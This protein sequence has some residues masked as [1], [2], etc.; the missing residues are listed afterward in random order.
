MLRLAVCLDYVAIVRSV[1]KG[2]EPDPVTAA[3]IAE[4]AGVDG[5]ACHFSEDKRFIRERDLLLLKEV[6]K[7]H[8]NVQIAPTEEMVKIALKVSSDMVTFV[9]EIKEG[10]PI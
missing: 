9:P 4:A 3:V 6:V 7:S 5:I 8:F 1:R 10:Q 2:K